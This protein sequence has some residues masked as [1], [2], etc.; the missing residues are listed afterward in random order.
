MW[1][2]N[3]TVDS[4]VPRDP[5]LKEIRRL[6]SSRGLGASNALP[7]VVA[8]S[9]KRCLADH[10]L[11][12]DKVPRAEILTHSEIRSL[13]ETH[14][15]LLTTA[16][17]EVEKLFLRLVD[18]EYLVSFASLQGVMLLFR[19]DYQFLNE[20]S[21]SGVLPGS[22]WTEE[23]Q[24]TNGV[25][26]GLR[27][28]KPITI[29]GNQHYGLAAQSLTC[30]TAPVMGRCGE[31][32]GIINVTTARTG[33]ERTNRVVQNIVEHAARRIESRFFGRVHRDSLLL[34]I[35]DDA[36]SGDMAEEGRLALDSTGR[37][38]ASSSQA[39]RMTGESIDDLLGSFA[40]ELFE[41]PI[42]LCD[43]RPEKP[44][45][46]VYQGKTMQGIIS[47]PEARKHSW[48]GIGASSSVPKPAHGTDVVHLSS[49]TVSLDKLR[50]DPITA[51][52]MD[53]AQ[54]LLQAGLPLVVTG[55]PG[56]GKTTFA[57]A[58]A[59][60]SLGDD[61]SLVLID[62]A[63]AFSNKLS[64]AW[65]AGRLPENSCLILDRFD[66]IDE[67]TQAMLL[68]LLEHELDGGTSQQKVIA[69]AEC[70]LD[71]IAKDGKIGTS[72]LHRLKGGSI[73]L[74][75]LRSDPNLDE[76]IEDFLRMELAALG[77]PDLRLDNEARLVLRNY[78][79]PGNHRELRNALRH[80]AVLTDRKMIHLEDLPTDIVSEMARKDLT[81]RSQSEAARIEAA[82]RY[83][84][85]N[86]SLTARYLGVS[87][88][89]LYRK[90]HIQKVRE[91]GGIRANDAPSIVMGVRE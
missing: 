50:S 33:D 2:E 83:N 12:P 5:V 51:S 53:R 84:G 34:R 87:R 88:A 7:E 47:V 89:T 69:I 4:T 85:G 60:R 27:V 29:I 72:L 86:L 35:S 59:R 62:C 45:S 61:G 19:C 52:A 6:T 3:K 30:I 48:N 16:A 21:A 9:W 26:T 39:A 15:D 40:E 68:S 49:R 23:R 64:V 55:E 14:E 36:E 58:V 91:E 41:L 25:G 43:I 63:T 90:I 57:R 80:A 78:H 24:G 65:P 42:P 75:P 74:P 38:V 11:R 67:A 81:A 77:R 31:M 22:V 73:V 82:L 66:Q 17:P 10:N 70:D 54:R 44:F 37:I 46:L 76:T 71:Q 18:S 56:S 13:N 8:D 28:G 79:W 32:Q 20:M 1:E